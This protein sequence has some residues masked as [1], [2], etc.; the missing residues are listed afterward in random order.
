MT[1]LLYMQDFDVESCEARVVS[2]SPSEDERV[3]IVLDQTCFYPRG[4][5][6]DWDTGVITGADAGFNVAAVHL[7]EHGTVHHIGQFSN[8][9]LQTGDR[10]SA[11]VDHKRRSINTR[12]HS[13]GH[14]IDMAIDYLGLDWIATKGQHY[15]HLSAVEY[16]GTWEPER[17]EELRVAI[18]K[19]TNAFTAQDSKNS[20]K[21]MPV[22]AMHTVC[23]H[24][25]DNIP[26]N[27][28]GRVIIYGG[29][30]GIPC[31]GTHV[32]NLKQIGTIMV[33]KLKEKKGVI[34]VSYNV[35]GITPNVLVAH[36]TP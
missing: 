16:S 29:N 10:V 26:K 31:G 14:V 22:E 21:F 5:G 25:P 1:E 11:V 18:E 19:Q 4:G 20:L 27:K 28:P 7:D 12:L 15:P 9:I 13:A 17:A 24:V 23:R 35:E 33:P 8:G 3:D 6:Q 36:A 2:V 34:R 30:F 32:K